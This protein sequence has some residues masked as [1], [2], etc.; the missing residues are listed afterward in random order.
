[1]YEL[2]EPDCN[3]FAIG[4]CFSEE[5]LQAAHEAGRASRDSAVRTLEQL[6][7]TDEGGEFWKPPIGKAPDFD[8][9]DSLRA[10]IASI[11]QAITD[12]ENQPSQFGT[13][14]LAMHE[15]T[16]KEVE[17]LRA[18]ALRYKWLRDN[19]PRLI[20]NTTP[21]C[22]GENEDGTLILRTY[23]QHFD[24]NENFRLAV[25]ESVDQAIDA[26]RKEK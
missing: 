17:A 6:G 8:F 21:V 26:A 15:A 4:P 5:K 13:I 22:L 1:M 2:P 12:P 3:P 9:I 16:Q 19:F 10:E 7:Y 18:D 24:V 14:T 23:V 11:H 20:V 25:P